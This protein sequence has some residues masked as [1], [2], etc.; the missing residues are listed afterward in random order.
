VDVGEDASCSGVLRSHG[1]KITFVR[2]YLQLGLAPD[3][4][5]AYIRQKWRWVCYV[6]HSFKFLFSQTIQLG[7]YR[8]TVL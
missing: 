5:Q 7:G 4:F 2:E 8:P 3:S 6:S 1:W